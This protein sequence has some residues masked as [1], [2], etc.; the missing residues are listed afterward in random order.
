[1]WSKKFDAVDGGYS[2]YCDVN[3]MYS[4]LSADGTSGVFQQIS[5]HLKQAWYDLYRVY[6]KLTDLSISDFSMLGLSFTLN[7][8]LNGKDTYVFKSSKIDGRIVLNCTITKRK[9][10][11]CVIS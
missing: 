8:L 2:V 5:T 4:F 10:N 9:S 1:M 3:V 7:F 11:M 6:P